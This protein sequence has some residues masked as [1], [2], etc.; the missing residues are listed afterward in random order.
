MGVL[1]SD[2]AGN[3]MSR[4]PT[5]ENEQR[6]VWELGKGKAE[7]LCG[8]PELT[9]TKNKQTKKQMTPERTNRD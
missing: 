6:A 8:G 9:F 4:L 1:G 3:G 7:E 2:G 5:V